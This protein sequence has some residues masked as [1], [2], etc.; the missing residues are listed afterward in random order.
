[1]GWF[2][3]SAPEAVVLRVETPDGFD[4]PAKTQWAFT[5]EMQ[6][7][8]GLGISGAILTDTRLGPEVSMHHAGDGQE[9]SV[10]PAKR[11][12]TFDFTDFKGDF[13]SL[14]VAFP[15]EGVKDVSNQDLL[16]VSINSTSD[17]PFD[18]FMR[19]NLCYGPNNEKLGRMLRIGEGERFAEFD[20]FYTEFESG[21]ATKIWTDLIINDPRGKVFTLEEIVILRRARASL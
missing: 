16:R 12:L 6:T 7:P 8:A 19:L 1:M 18:L 9:F 17:T 5:P 2:G 4:V 10:E 13:F 11:G 15:S 20:L 3:K 21:R 14:A